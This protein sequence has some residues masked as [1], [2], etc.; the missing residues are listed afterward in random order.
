[1]RGLLI[2]VA[3]TLAL[4][5]TGYSKEPSGIQIVEAIPVARPED[6]ID[7]GLACLTLAKEVYP[8]SSA[9]MSSTGYSIAWQRGSPVFRVIPRILNNELVS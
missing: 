7:I 4:S 8:E 5:V 1:M 2:I 3:M 6:R 9:L